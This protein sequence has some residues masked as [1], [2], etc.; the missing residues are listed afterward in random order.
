MSFYLGKHS[1]ENLRGVHPDLVKVVKRAIELTKVDFKVIKGKRTEARQRQLVV[2][3]K[4]QTM[5]CRHLTGH[6]VDCAPLVAGIIPWNDRKAFASVSKAMFSAA[7]E[8]GIPLL[9]GLT[10]KQWA[11]MHG[12]EGEPRD[13]MTVDRLEHI[14]YLERTNI[15]LL[16]I[17]MDYP[18]REAE[19]TRLSQ[20]WMAKQL[21]VR[22]EKSC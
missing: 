14:S 1:L 22:N 2:N 9:G 4:S 18:Q 12:I 11:K 8:L 7:N 16:D 3:G 17:G 6:A 10:A 19:L 5:N 21:G 20:R 13:A 15:T